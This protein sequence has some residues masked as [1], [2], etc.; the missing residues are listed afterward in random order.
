MAWLGNDG[1]DWKGFDPLRLFS[2]YDLEGFAVYGRSCSWVPKPSSQIKNKNFLP[3]P[4]DSDIVLCEMS[5]AALVVTDVR[6]LVMV[7]D[8]LGATYKQSLG[9]RCGAPWGQDLP[10]CGHRMYSHMAGLFCA[11]PSPECRRRHPR[12]GSGLFSGMP[13]RPLVN[14]MF[15]SKRTI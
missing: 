14:F 13:S 6:S 7:D 1:P 2:R 15:P 10:R 12:H 11:P 5:A 8:M 9:N 3:I 4:T